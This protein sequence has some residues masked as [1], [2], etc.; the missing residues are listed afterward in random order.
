M[1]GSEFLI[2]QYLLSE[3]VAEQLIE[4]DHEAF[5]FRGERNNYLVEVRVYDLGPADAP[6]RRLKEEA[7]G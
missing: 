4:R 7:S 5:V 1:T 6:V 2:E 3:M